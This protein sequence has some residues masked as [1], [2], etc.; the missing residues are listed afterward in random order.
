[1]YTDPDPLRYPT[2]F[3]AKQAILQC[4]KAGKLFAYMDIHAHSTKRGC[5]LFGNSIEEIDFQ[6]EENL[7]G[8]LMSLNSPN[9]DY[10][11]SSFNDDKNNVKD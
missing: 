11:E 7:L 9:F 10:R 2:I 3:A 5:F 6:I 8:K 4:H 1:M